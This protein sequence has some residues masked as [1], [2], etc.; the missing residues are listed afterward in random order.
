MTIPVRLLASLVAAAALTGCGGSSGDS[1]AATGTS[2]EPAP[3]TTSAAPGGSPAAAGPT[4]G[5]VVRPAASASQQ[6]NAGPGAASAKPSPQSSPEEL[7]AQL[8]VTCVVPGGSMTMTLHARPGM[9]VIFDTRYPDGKDG[10]VYGGFEPQGHTDPN[11]TYTRTWQVDAGAPTGKADA[12]V[13]AADRQ[14][15]GT[16]R[17]PFRVATTC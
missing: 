15:S 13:G 16:K 1:R 7:D 12:T 9:T 4:V 3:S 8:S 5:P 17:M 11:G 14:G 10:Q 6:P 2:P